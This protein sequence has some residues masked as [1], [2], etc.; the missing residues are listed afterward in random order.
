MFTSSSLT[1]Y[2]STLLQASLPSGRTFTWK[3]APGVTPV[4]MGYVSIWL[5]QAF[6]AP[7]RARVVAH[8]VHEGKT[9]VMMKFVEVT[10]QVTADYANTEYSIRY[11]KYLYKLPWH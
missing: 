11:Q 5:R 3:D 9:I 1:S 2:V 8:T 6:D 7:N 10:V 4:G